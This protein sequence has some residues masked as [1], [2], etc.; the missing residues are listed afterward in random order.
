MVNKCCVLVMV[1]ISLS[2]YIGCEHPAPTPNKHIGMRLLHARIEKDGQV[3]L[4]TSFCVSEQFGQ[5]CR[6]AAT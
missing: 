3:I 2:I 6:M 4:H 5:T 1:G